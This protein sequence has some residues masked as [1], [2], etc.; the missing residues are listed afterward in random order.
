M[1]KNIT[2]YGFSVFEDN[3]SI[4]DFC[5]KAVSELYFKDY[6]SIL[7][8]MHFLLYTINI[9]LYYTCKNYFPLTNDYT[10]SSSYNQNLIYEIVHY[11]NKNMCNKDA[12]KNITSS[13]NYSYS[14]L[15]HI[16]SKVTGENL[17][18][19]FHKLRMNAAEK[20]LSDGF[21]VTETAY[22]FNYSSIH[23]FSRAYKA[24]FNKNPVLSKSKTQT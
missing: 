20:K 19:F 2:S 15:S 3:F 9:V 22:Y 5:K 7:P 1:Q 10:P 16:F 21:S 11:L 13:I 4:T 12:L 23:T 17:K 14:H 18:E 6:N 8:S 24:F